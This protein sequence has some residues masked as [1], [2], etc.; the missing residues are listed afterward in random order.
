MGPPSI[1]HC[2]S[3]G[4]QRLYNCTLGN[5]KHLG[6]HSYLGLSVARKSCDNAAV[7]L[8][9]NSRK[10]RDMIL[11]AIARNIFMETAQADICLR[12][13]HI[14]GKVNEIADSLSRWN[15][16]VHYQQKFYHLL[17]IHVWTKIPDKALEI[18]W[19]I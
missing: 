4:V 3:H 5:V 8:L 17:P 16:G 19:S 6:C 2:N 18:N 10:T 13:T 7:V 9:L 14:M 12:T 15:M 1:Y 11:A